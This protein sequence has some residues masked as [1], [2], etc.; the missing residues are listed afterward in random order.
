MPEQQ[1]PQ[2]VAQGGAG[3]SGIRKEAGLDMNMPRGINLPDTTPS[4]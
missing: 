2:L 3:A 1:K 4:F